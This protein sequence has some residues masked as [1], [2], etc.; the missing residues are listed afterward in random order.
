MRRAYSLSNLF[1]Q[2]SSL[3]LRFEFSGEMLIQG[4]Q[5]AI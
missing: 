1:V 4:R 5:G 3:V 2:H